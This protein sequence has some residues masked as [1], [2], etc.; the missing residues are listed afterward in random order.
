MAEAVEHED[1]DSTDPSELDGEEELAD[2]DIETNVFGDSEEESA[3][4]VDDVDEDPLSESFG[5]DDDHEAPD[6]GADADD[7]HTG[8][9]LAS[10]INDGCARLA[11]VGL[12]EGEQKDDLNEE[13]QEVFSEFRLGYYAEATLEEYVFTDD[14]EEVPPVWGLLGAA[15]VCTVLVVVRRPDGDELL[16]GVG[17]QMPSIM[18][19]PDEQTTANEPEEIEN[20]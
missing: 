15:V 17:L 14:I 7:D 4:D 5:E 10:S 3:V 16:D 20:E 2:L 13:F 12:E 18:D 11:V 1:D 6:I 8:G 19:E 9:A